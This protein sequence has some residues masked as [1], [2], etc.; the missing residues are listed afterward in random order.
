MD[1]RPVSN[2]Q[3]VNDLLAPSS[4]KKQPRLSQRR[5]T[6][7]TEPIAPSVSSGTSITTLPLK[8]FLCHASED[9][10]RVRRLYQR[11]SADGYDPWLDEKKLLPGHNWKQEIKKALRA[12]DAAVVCFSR[13]AVTK[14][15]FVHVEVREILELA[16]TRPFGR[17]FLIPVRINDCELPDEISSNYH[18]VDL[19]R[20]H[21]Y[22]DLRRSL[23]LLKFPAT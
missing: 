17:V 3:F 2:R 5:S 11:L 9:K 14:N 15:G 23:D 10:P 13:T 19:Y 6:R 21:G 1:P 16:A 12:S 20:P 18:R 4:R 8:V 22:R 7:L